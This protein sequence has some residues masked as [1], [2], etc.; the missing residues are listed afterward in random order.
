VRFLTAGIPL[1]SK[2][3]TLNGLER[4]NELG[5]GGME[6]E[7]VHGVWMTP[8]KAVEVKA[9]ADEKNLVLTAHGPYYINLLSADF[10]K[11]N[12]SVGRIV[13]AARALSSCRGKSL[14]FHAAFYG[15]MTPDEAYPKLRK[16]VNEIQ[17]ILKSEKVNVW[18]RPETTGRKTQ[19]G[20]LDEI[21][22]LA[23]DCNMVLPC[24]DFAHLFA[25]AGG[26]ADWHGILESL[27]NGLGKPALKNLHCH[28]SGI[29]YDIHGEKNHL[30]LEE[31][32]MDWRGLL[33][34]LHEFGCDGAVVSE[35]PNIEGDA[36]LMQKFWQGL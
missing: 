6:L 10:Q 24:I 16:K 31:C 26:K 8:E 27:E 17:E 15:G 34:T 3:G 9:A 5:L 21:L 20:T 28:V 11:V 22:K 36:L 13:G 1:S 12:E 32:G 7:F 30:I 29:E 23:G 2:Q 25:R 19:W 14:T 4:V 35:S 18:I 33:K